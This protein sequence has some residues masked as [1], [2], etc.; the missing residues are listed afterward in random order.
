MTQDLQPPAAPV[1]ARASRRERLAACLVRAR[2]GDS[3]AIEEMVH[4]LNPLLWHVARSQGLDASTAADVVQTTWLELVRRLHEI[5]VP[6][7]LAGWLTTVARNEAMKVHRRSRQVIPTDTVELPDDPGPDVVDDLVAH[8]RARSLWRSF[9]QLSERCQQLLR[10]VA[11]VD[12]PDYTAISE[13][14]G[15]PHGSIGP[16]RG[17][18]LTKLR[19]LLLAD[20]LWEAP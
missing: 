14:M 20:P 4:D 13:A 15:M 17:R 8:E 7:A 18:C 3:A 9:A 19:E 1:D 2:A 16:T 5:R 11:Q 12:R 6:E 10:V